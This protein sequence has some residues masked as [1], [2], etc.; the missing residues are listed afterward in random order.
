MHRASWPR[1]AYSL[2]KTQIGSQISPFSPPSFSSFIFAFSRVCALIV[3]TFFVD[4]LLTFAP[5]IIFSWFLRFLRPGPC[6][7][8]RQHT[9]FPLPKTGQVL[10]EHWS[11]REKNSW[12]FANAHAKRRGARGAYARTQ[13]NL[14]LLPPRTGSIRVNKT[15]SH[16]EVFFGF[17]TRFVLRAAC[18]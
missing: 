18:M 2:K 4:W 3:K 9:Y 5:Q 1:S 10:K 8:R 6:L 14:T 11:D 15:S 7:Y 12:A 16:W 13:T 17:H